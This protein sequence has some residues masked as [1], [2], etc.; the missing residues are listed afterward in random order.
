MSPLCTISFVWTS[1]F[2]FLSLTISVPVEFFCSQV[3]TL[4]MFANILKS[5]IP[6]PFLCLLNLFLSLLLG[7]RA[8][9]F[10]DHMTIS[11]SCPPPL[12]M[13]S[14]PRGVAS[15]A[16]SRPALWMPPTLPRPPQRTTSTPTSQIHPG[17]KVETG[18]RHVHVASLAE[19]CH[20]LRTSRRPVLPV[21]FCPVCPPRRPHFSFGCE[22]PNKRL[23]KARDVEAILCSI[24]CFLFNTSTQ[25]WL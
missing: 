2:A 1:H 22:R 4:Q 24:S 9:I 12:P 20:P 6:S 21:L 18:Q 5:S 10:W 11:Q 23:A 8:T 15:P 19:T 3:S 17:V 14:S 16:Q 13:C 7:S 25:Q